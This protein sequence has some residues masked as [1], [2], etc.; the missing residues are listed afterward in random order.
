MD[1][2]RSATDNPSVSLQFK[3]KQIDQLT[4]CVSVL[5]RTNLSLHSFEWNGGCSA[6]PFIGNVQ[7]FSPHL[8]LSSVNQTTSADYRSRTWFGDCGSCALGQTWY[9]FFFIVCWSNQSQHLFRCALVKVIK[10]WS[11]VFIRKKGSETYI[12]EPVIS[13]DTIISLD[14]RAVTQA[15]NICVLIGLSGSQQPELD[16]MLVIWRTPPVFDFARSTKVKIKILEY[17]LFSI[18]WGCYV[19]L[20]LTRT[21]VM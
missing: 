20:G 19:A 10:N 14:K 5:K 3:K 2:T 8:Q 6:T 17:G 16:S 7:F 12:S 21:F 1:G 4:G 18:Y 15:F 11:P 13:L 9:Y